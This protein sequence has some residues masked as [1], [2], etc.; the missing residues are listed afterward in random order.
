VEARLLTVAHLGPAPRATAVTVRGQ[1]LA[2]SIGA[3]DELPAAE[4]LAGDADVSGADVIWQLYTEDIV[5]TYAAGHSLDEAD[6]DWTCLD[7]IGGWPVMV[8]S[9]ASS[10]ACWSE[11]R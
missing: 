10:A 2:C 5:C 8:N 3:E 1:R 11:T 4:R 7:G 9:H 6:V